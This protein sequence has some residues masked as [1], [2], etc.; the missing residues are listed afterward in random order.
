M[1]NASTV[2]QER[3]ELIAM[4]RDSVAAFVPP[5]ADLR[6]IRQLRFGTPGFD[7][8][9]WRQMCA[10]G[11]A[12]LRV[13]EA[14]GGSGLGLREF[15][16]V[17]EGL[18]VGLVPEPLI[19]CAM[20]AE[21]LDGDALAAL[22]GGARVI[23]PAWQEKPHSLELAGA[24]RLQA[25]RVSGR[26]V[27]VP[28]AGGADAFLVT[29]ASGLA[30]VERAAPGLTLELATTQDG[31]QFGTL[32]LDKVPAQP[33]A[34]GLDAAA[35]ALDHA[36]LAS[37]AYLLGVTER[38]FAITL[39]Y[40]KVRKQ[41]GKVIGSF[42]ALQHRAVDLRIQIALL[43]ASVESAAATLDAQPGA[44]LRQAVVSRAKAR[45]AEAALLVSRQAVQ[46]HGAMGYTD[47][48]DVGLYLR[49]AMTLASL[50]GSADVHRARYAQVAAGLDAA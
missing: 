8:A 17:A 11:W 7:A 1:T 49:K 30:L 40:L 41:F 29:T 42:Q 23:V 31:G 50:Y 18:G 4:V 35:A 27:F 36:A 22:L 19:A 25:G 37:A 24:T 3:A 2:E 48:Y 46:L 20:A 43:R 47:E 21:L 5:G 14:A 44:A 38:A 45:A 34:A 15:C 33:V 39:D 28:M 26:K 16:A 10:L 32:T 9:T 13:P 12:G 6:R